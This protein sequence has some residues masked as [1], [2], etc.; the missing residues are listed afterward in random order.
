MT[1]GGTTTIPYQPENA[2]P[3]TWRSLSYIQGISESVTRRLNPYNVKI[4]HKPHSELKSNLVHVKGPVPTLHRRKII[5]HIPCSVCDRISTG[6]TDRLLNWLDTRIL[7]SANSLRPHEAI[8]ALNSGEHS[9][10]QFMQLDLCDRSMRVHH[11]LTCPTA[12]PSQIF[13]PR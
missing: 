10:N 12:P 11:W 3:I 9:I 7:G 8:E 4:A 13:L 6:K 1:T 5:H 2:P